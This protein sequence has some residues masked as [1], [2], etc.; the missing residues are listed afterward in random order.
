MKVRMIPILVS[1][2]GTIPEAWKKDWRNWEAENE[3]RL[4]GQLGG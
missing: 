4:Y 1:G 3:S 2:L